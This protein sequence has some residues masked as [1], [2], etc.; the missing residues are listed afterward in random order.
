M[1]TFEFTLVLGDLKEVTGESAE[2]IFEAGC[3]EGTFTSS[4]GEAEVQFDCEAATLEAAVESA[5]SQIESAGITVAKV[6]SGEFA[7]IHRFN[8][9]LAQV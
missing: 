3:D 8:E 4:N 6:E 1:K 9:Q 7:T 2:K 5:I